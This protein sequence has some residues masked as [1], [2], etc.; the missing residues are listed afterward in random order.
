MRP[1][2]DLANTVTVSAGGEDDLLAPD[3]EYERWAEAEAAALGWG[4]ERQRLL[5]DRREQVLR[6]R[7]DVRRVVGA[8]VDGGPVPPAAVEE[9]NRLSR[10][11]PEWLELDP[12]T[13]RLVRPGR[14]GA[15]AVLLA[16]YARDALRIAAGDG[17]IRRCPA[18]SCGMFFPPGRRQQRWCSTTCGTR[19]RVARHYARGVSGRRSRPGGR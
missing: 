19:A 17:E 8:V 12:S 11:A 13:G 16:D 5:V 9:L 3:G 1:A 2:L 14:G 18:P 6:T 4:A 10:A 15:A 7:A